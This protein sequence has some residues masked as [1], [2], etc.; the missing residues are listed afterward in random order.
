[1]QV[2]T[3]IIISWELRSYENTQITP[4]SW[5]IIPSSV[6]AEFQYGSWMAHLA[7]IVVYIEFAWN[8]ISFASNYY[9]FMKTTR[10]LKP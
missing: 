3:Q 2:L 5:K 6:T 9:Y 1:M 7:L 4:I 8:Y 10:L